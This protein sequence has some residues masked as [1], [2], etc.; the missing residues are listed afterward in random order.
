MSLHY[1]PHEDLHAKPVPQPEGSEPHGAD[2]AA[3]AIINLTLALSGISFAANGSVAGG[4]VMLGLI[5]GF[6]VLALTGRS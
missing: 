5:A 1:Y 4:L 6:N 2:F 3:I